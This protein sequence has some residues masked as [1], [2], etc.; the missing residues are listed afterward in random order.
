MEEQEVPKLTEIE[1]FRKLVND[2][3]VA[4]AGKFDEKIMAIEKIME[5][6]EKQV[7]TLIVGF[8][9]QAV[10]LEALMGQLQFATPEAQ[11]D[12]HETLSNSRKQMLTIMKEGA[13]GLLAD[14]NESLA[15]AIED[16]A[17]SKHID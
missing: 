12:F 15:S 4:L 17:D 14:E 6:Y 9:E 2:L 1:E 3:V 16:L 11:K 10:F 7:A 8:G 13:R 5:S